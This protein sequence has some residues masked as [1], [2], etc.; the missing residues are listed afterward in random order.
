MQG[1]YLCDTFTQWK[2]NL[3]FKNDL[4]QYSL[5]PGCFNLFLY[6]YKLYKNHVLKYFLLMQSSE[7]K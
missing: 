4:L 2:G 3:C 1:L 7:T 5:E 6:V